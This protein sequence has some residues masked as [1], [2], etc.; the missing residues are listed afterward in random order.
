MVPSQFLEGIGQDMNEDGGR[1]PLINLGLQEWNQLFILLGVLVKD[2]SQKY[3]Q[4]LF[5]R[6]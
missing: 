2:G 1:V 3:L 4:A 6:V 5:F